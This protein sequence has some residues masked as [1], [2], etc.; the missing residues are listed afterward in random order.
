[1]KYLIKNQ[2]RLLAFFL[3]FFWGGG[4]VGEGGGG[5]GGVGEWGKGMEWKWNPPC[6][7]INHHA[8]T[9]RYSEP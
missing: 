2:L 4:G 5:S 9:S 7:I 1:M 8:Y 3:N 6:K